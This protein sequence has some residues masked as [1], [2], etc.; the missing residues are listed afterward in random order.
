MRR[1]IYPEKNFEESDRVDAGC[2]IKVVCPT[3]EDLDFLVE[4]IGVPNSFV[5]D[6]ADSDERPRIEHEDEWQLTIIRI[7]IETPEANT[8]Y[9]TVPVGIIYSEERNVIATICYHRTQLIPDFIEHN[10]RKKI[11]VHTE[12]DFIL[13]LI[14]SSA[15]WFLK[16]LK[17]INFMLLEAEEALEKSIRNEDLL[18]IMKLQ[19]CFVY[20]NT[21]IRGNES[22]M[23]KLKTLRYNNYDQELA[24]DV[25][26]ELNQAYNMVN[27]YS[28]ILTGT[29]DAFASII[30]NNVNT[31]MKRMTS[32]S[33]VLML[34]T[35][36]A[37]LY[38]MNVP[39]P[40]SHIP[41]AFGAILVLCLLLSAFA[42]W[43]FKKVKWF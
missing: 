22:V 6:T 43:Y 15:V 18:Q 35:L 33:I 17:Q 8:P 13:R 42:F 32:I 2:W 27:V 36:V 20:F 41:Y 39:L 30:S 24:E 31:I 25:A 29:M 37:S 26:I 16:Y 1:F 14:L 11:S 19:K 28:D 34:P 40:F 10:R 21:S 4:E 38:G 9:N 5:T 7:P 12:T 23:G 3:S